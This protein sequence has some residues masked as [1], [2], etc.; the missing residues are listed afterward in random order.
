MDIKEACIS[1]TPGPYIV[2]QIKLP[3]DISTILNWIMLVIRLSSIPIFA[4]LS[5]KSSYFP[6]SINAKSKS[7]NN[8]FDVF[9]LISSIK[10]IQMDMD[11]MQ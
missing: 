8:R 5:S 1:H 6:N 9:V 3:L 7:F 2:I 4:K 11:G 10:Y